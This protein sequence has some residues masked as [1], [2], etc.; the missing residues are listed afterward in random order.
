MELDAKH[1]NCVSTITK[2]FFKNLDSIPKECNSIELNRKNSISICRAAH[3]AILYACIIFDTKFCVMHVEAIKVKGR[4]SFVGRYVY[5]HLHE[6]A[7]QYC[8]QIF[9]IW[10][11]YFCVGAY[12]FFIN[13][14]KF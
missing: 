4:D 1:R 13:A 5:Y 7:G 3:E 2:G 14:K 11:T 10:P 9:L 6:K 8:T 12:M